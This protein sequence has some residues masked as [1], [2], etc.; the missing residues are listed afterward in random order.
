MTEAQWLKGNKPAAMLM[1]LQ[2]EMAGRADARRKVRLWAAA[3]C[4]LIWHLFENPKSRKLIETSERYADGEVTFREL[5]TLW[6]A[7][8][9]KVGRASW[10]AFLAEGVSHRDIWQGTLEGW[11]SLS[12][13]PAKPAVQDVVMADLFREIFG[14]P[15]R[16]VVF[17]PEWHTD[18]VV[19]LARTM[20]ESRDFSAMPILA[21]ALQD[22]G[23]DNEDI[24]NHCRSPGPHARGCW[25]VDL[26]LGKE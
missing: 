10:G 11:A 5:K 19:A 22:A 6:D 24:L 4:R 3:C 26:V 12:S 14:N 9:E 8:R 7:H 2:E 18:T 15:F 20:Y 13:P 23:C 21:D 16:P 17:A 1:F 25:V